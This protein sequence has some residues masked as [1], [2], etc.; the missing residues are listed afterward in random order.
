MFVTLGFFF[1]PFIYKIK[2]KKLMVSTVNLQPNLSPPSFF[3]LRA[4]TIQCNS[5]HLF[6]AFV[7]GGIGWF[8]CTYVKGNGPS[9]LSIFHISLSFSLSPS[10]FSYRSVAQLL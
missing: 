9:L 6:C 1:G 3:K 4:C 8:P 2:K 10:L 5:F 7:G